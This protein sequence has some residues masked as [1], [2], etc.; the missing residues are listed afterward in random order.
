MNS[1]QAK[2]H[3]FHHIS[4]IFFLTSSSQVGSKGVG[5]VARSKAGDIALSLAAFVP[6]VEAVVWIS[7]C[8]ANVATPLYYKKS[9]ILPALMFDLSKMIP[10]ESGAYLVK[11]ALHNPLAEENKATLV[12][13]EQ[14]KGRFLFAAAEDDLNWDTKAY[15]DEM[16]ER[17]KHHG[18]ENFESV[19]YPGAGHY[20]EPPY[21]PYCPSSFNRAASKPVLWGGEAR[22]HAAA[23][24][25]LWK[26]ILDFLRAHLSCDDTHTK[27]KL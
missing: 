16:V 20:L 18:K 19:S 22:S 27:A 7:G 9:Q 23:E 25:H 6:S 21:G 8:S 5:V 17:L 12:P 10:T 3:L 13:I 1:T 26:K 4:I 15:M 2:T 11:N 24:V 14:A